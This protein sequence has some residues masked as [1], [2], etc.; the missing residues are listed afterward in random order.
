M[1]KSL[2]ETDGLSWIRK[3]QCLSSDTATFAFNRNSQRVRRADPAE[4]T[5][6]LQ[7]WF[8]SDFS[9]SATEEVR[10]LGRDGRTLQ[11]SAKVVSAEL[12]Q[13]LDTRNGL[14]GKIII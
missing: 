1:S 5:S 9:V 4:G 3:G 14:T 2:K 8:G 6:D 10:G 11:T 12:A 7:D 13:H